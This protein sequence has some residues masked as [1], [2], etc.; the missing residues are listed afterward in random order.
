MYAQQYATIDIAADM[1][2]PESMKVVQELVDVSKSIVKDLLNEMT[3]LVEGAEEQVHPLADVIEGHSEIQPLAQTHVNQDTTTAAMVDDVETLLVNPHVFATGASPELDAPQDALANAECLHIADGAHSSPLF[4]NADEAE[5]E[6]EAEEEEEA[7]AEADAYFKKKYMLPEEQQKEFEARWQSRKASAEAA[8]ESNARV[9]F[10][11][12]QR[13]RVTLE[14]AI[15]TLLKDYAEIYER[16]HALRLLFEDEK[17]QWGSK[18]QQETM[19]ARMQERAQVRA[20]ES[21]RWD[22]KRQRTDTWGS[23]FSYPHQQH[24]R[25]HNQVSPYSFAFPHSQPRGALVDEFQY[26]VEDSQEHEQGGIAGSGVEGQ[27]ALLHSDMCGLSPH[28]KQQKKF[29]VPVKMT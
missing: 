1:S 13:D 25:Q 7:E 22:V 16:A 15:D 28:K 10:R 19:Q 26:A 2:V 12:W 8:A 29:T 14:Q 6:A 23:A 4:N 11:Q 27:A 18:I 3:E 17:A 24:Q 20:E 21:P 5:A 9:T